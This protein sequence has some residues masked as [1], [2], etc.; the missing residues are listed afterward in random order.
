M[1]EKKLHVLSFLGGLVFLSLL[2]GI[3]LS[4]NSSIRAEVENQA[5]GF[6]DAG[7][8]ILFQLQTILAKVSQITGETREVEEQEVPSSEPAIVLSDGYDALW[9]TVEAQNELYVK[10]HPS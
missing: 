6:L 1:N 2:T 9:S 5:K 3:L 8:D 4:R 7:R 10:S